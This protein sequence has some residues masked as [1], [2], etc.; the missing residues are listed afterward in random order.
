[1]NSEHQAQILWQKIDQLMSIDRN[2]LRKRIARWRKQPNNAE[3]ARIEKAIAASEQRVRERRERLPIPTFPSDLPVTAKLIELKQA[4]ADHQVLIV[5]GETGSGKTTQLPK[6]CLAL[7]RGIYGLIA[8]TQPRRIAARTVAS[9]I[10]EELNSELGQSVG[11]KVRFSDQTS[12]DSYIKVMTDG[13]LLA[14]TQQD[15]L[16]MQYDTLIVDEAHERSLNIDFILGYCKQLL[17]RRPELKLI[18]TSAT[19]D[20]ERFA[21]HFGRAPIIEVSGRLYPIEVR[22]RPLAREEEDDEQPLEEAI[23]DTVV[24]LAR[25]GSGDILVFLPGERE[26]HETAGLL[27]ADLLRR[28][29]PGAMEIVPLYARLSHAEQQRAFVTHAHCKVVLATNVAETSLTVPGIRYV[30]DSGLARIARYSV[31]N[32]VQLLQIEKISQASANQ[33][34]GRCGRVSDGICVRLYSTDDYSARAIYSE[35]E[36][37]RSSLAAVILRMA[38]LNLSAIEDF[39]FIDPPNTRAIADGYQLLQ[40][41]GAMSNERELTSIGREMAKLPIDPRLSRMILAAKHYG[42]VAEVLVIAAALSVLDP[43]QRPLE[44]A[45]AADQ[46]HQRFRDQR[47][48]FL[49]YLHLWQFF[50]EISAEEKSQRKTLARCRAHYLSYLRLREWRDIHHQLVEILTEAGWRFD[51]KLPVDLRYEAIHH[52]LLAGLLGNIGSAA[53]NGEYLGARGIKFYLHPATGVQRKGT[54]WVIAAELMETSRLYARIIARIEPEWIEQAAGDLVKRQYLDPRWHQSRAEVVASE[55]VSLYGLVLV[56]RREVSY[57]KINPPEAHEIFIRA[58]VAGEFAQ[59]EPFVIH[60]RRVL[61]EVAELADKTRRHDITVDEQD[62]YLFYASRILEQVNS[63]AGFNAWWREFKQREPERLNMSVAALLQD[64]RQNISEE[65]F[66]KHLTIAGAKLPLKYRFDPGHPRDGITLI[67]PLALLNQIDA[68]QIDWLVPGMIREKVNW[69]VKSLPKTWRNRLLPHAEF[70]TRFLTEVK[71]HDKKVTDALKIFI[72][73]CLQEKLPAIVWDEKLLPV[74][75]AVNLRIVDADGR[76]LGESRNLEELREKL[77]QAAQ[78]TFSAS[79][80]RIER[81]GITSWDFGELPE[82]ISF[83]RIN[84]GKAET[85]TGYPALLADQQSV[86]LSLLDT[87]EAALRAT[88]HGVIKLVQLQLKEQMK[89]L[90]RAWPGFEQVALYFRSL[91]QSEEL[92]ADV[93]K[94]ICDRAILGEDEIPRDSRTFKEQCDRARTRLPAVSQ[95]AQRLLAAIATAH[96]ELSLA[97]AQA[98]RNTQAIQKELHA[99]HQALIHRGFFSATPWPQ[100]S[101]IPR[102]LQALKRRLEKYPENLARDQKWSLVVNNLRQKYNKQ[103]AIVGGL[104]CANE[105]LSGF[106]WHL[107]ELSVSLFAQELKTPY[108]IS[109]KRLEKIWVALIQR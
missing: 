95:A 43:R 80:P 52:A 88:R 5:C 75:L 46:A 17:T 9:R 62:I 61:Q 4:I 96:H 26:I 79:E 39:P 69:Y 71:P 81:S 59:Q 42:V 34:A 2:P 48:D 82:A 36:I 55:R 8:H 97:L 83:K 16:L 11:Y 19:L 13:M 58:L 89:Q 33:R 102:Y 63:V 38:A 49:S 99:Q 47:S 85:L 94:A 92:K 98:G 103:L 21:I 78:F 60:N 14:E 108:P 91:G 3:L 27:A 1:M 51:A 41:L 86:R 65:Q 31:R 15:N 29:K 18:I 72:E 44:S 45:N 54:H 50:Q 100:L 25:E 73:G 107:E 30:I 67:I 24:E 90:E 101:H 109:I 7:G 93:I 84:H 105:A 87:R 70:V 32:K 66:P 56:A 37:L 74:H 12:V 23:V 57:A 6:I 53:E 76:E 106:R 77:G 20:A 68:A 104:E 35:P 40:E 28:K 22:H 64:R 10:A